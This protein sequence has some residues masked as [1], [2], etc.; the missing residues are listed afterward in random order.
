MTKY[1]LNK[2]YASVYW[3]VSSVKVLPPVYVG[4]NKNILSEPA[5]TT[6]S[7]IDSKTLMVIDLNFFEHDSVFDED[8]LPTIVGWN[9]SSEGNDQYTEDLFELI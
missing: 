8:E 7:G 3:K 9:D 6:C 1:L 5:R 4:V 2:G